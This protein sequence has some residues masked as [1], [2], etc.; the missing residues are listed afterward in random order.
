MPR[1][2]FHR[3]AASSDRHMSGQ[4]GNSLFSE[5]NKNLMDIC[6]NLHIAAWWRSYQLIS[7]TKETMFVGKTTA[8]C[9]NRAKIRLFNASTKCLRSVKSVLLVYIFI[10][11]A[12]FFDVCKRQTSPNCSLRRNGRKGGVKGL[13]PS[14]IPTIV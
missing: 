4:H 3:Q 9:H 7:S 11:H 13:C 1:P 12:T 6:K 10:S 2:Y 5:R 14:R 8:P